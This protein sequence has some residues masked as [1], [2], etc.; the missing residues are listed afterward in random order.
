[1]PHDTHY[2]LDKPSFRLEKNRYLTIII[3]CHYFIFSTK[4]SE[5]LAIVL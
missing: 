3:Y 2:S 4:N 1:M 5:L